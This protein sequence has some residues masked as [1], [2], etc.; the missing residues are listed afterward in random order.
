MQ[1]FYR[2]LFCSQIHFTRSDLR[3]VDIFL[4]S[5]TIPSTRISLLKY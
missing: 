3:A 5:M 1:M 2:C 4:L